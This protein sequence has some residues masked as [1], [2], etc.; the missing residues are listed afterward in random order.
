M[1]IAMSVSQAV[2]PKENAI[3]F[4]AR[5]KLNGLSGEIMNTIHVDNGPEFHSETFRNALYG[6]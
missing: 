5:F 1:S 4:C 3:S 2:L 6:T